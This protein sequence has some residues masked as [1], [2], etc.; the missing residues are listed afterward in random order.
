MA[1]NAKD[2]DSKKVKKETKEVKV[3]VTKEAKKETAAKKTRL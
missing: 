2:K 1:S 3:E